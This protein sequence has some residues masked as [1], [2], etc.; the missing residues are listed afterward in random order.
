[1][2]QVSDIQ[3]HRAN[4]NTTYKKRFFAFC[5]VNGTNYRKISKVKK[6]TQYQNVGRPWLKQ[7]WK[8]FFK[9]IKQYASQEPVFRTK[10]CSSDEHHTNFVHSWDK[11]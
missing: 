2:K 1:M 9:A 5:F 10:G 6:F 4:D 8:T 3:L 11:S 7:Y